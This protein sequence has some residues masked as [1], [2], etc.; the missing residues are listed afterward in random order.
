MCGICQL[1]NIYIRSWFLSI[2]KYLLLSSIFVYLLFWRS[3]HPEVLVPGPN[4]PRCTPAHCQPCPPPG[5]PTHRGAP[6]AEVPKDSPESLAPAGGEG[7]WPSPSLTRNEHIDVPPATFA[8]LHP[9]LSL[10][11]HSLQRKRCSPAFPPAKPKE[12][13]L[14]SLSTLMLWGWGRA[15]VYE[16]DMDCGFTG[17]YRLKTG[18]E[19]NSS[20]IKWLCCW[21]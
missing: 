6:R 21:A 19:V 17:Y 9:A 8:H 3:E 7:Q 1:L 10:H 20:G 2:N 12:L 16:A 4:P 18:G 11:P 15:G 5:W 13:S 14:L